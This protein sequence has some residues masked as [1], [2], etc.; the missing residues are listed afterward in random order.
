MDFKN[1]KNIMPPFPRTPHVPFN[2]NASADD[3][4]SSNK[5]VEILFQSDF[6]SVQ[7]K[8]DG[9]NC[10][11]T[12]YKGE[13]VIRNI[14]HILRKGYHKETP[15]KMQFAP[16]FGWF[17]KHKKLFEKLHDIAGPVGCYGEWLLAQHG[18]EYDLLPSL[19]LAFDLYDYESDFFLPTTVA[20]EMLIEAGFSV[21]PEIY[22]GKIVDPEHLLYLL[23][24]GESPFTTKSKRE[25]LYIKID[26]GTKIT[27]RFKMVR[28]DFVRGALWDK[29]ALKKNTVVA[30]QGG[31]TEVE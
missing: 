7:E 23:G 26:D 9:S 5:E 2:P 30:S 6:V 10:G 3:L 16:V 21:V 19:F 14:D 4:I 1:M 22:Y 11:M 28:P 8:V 20:R 12:L 13:P 18:I 24:Q 27:H 31:D 29:K 17:Y 25:G 15:A